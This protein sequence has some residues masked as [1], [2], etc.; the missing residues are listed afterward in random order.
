MSNELPF[1]SK[2]ESLCNSIVHTTHRLRQI[3]LVDCDDIDFNSQ[4]W[5]FQLSQVASSR[6]VVLLF[7]KI[8]S[9]SQI[10]KYNQIFKISFLF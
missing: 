7:Q 3:V 6:P 5:T 10:T 9:S 8:H 1:T 2:T 4:N